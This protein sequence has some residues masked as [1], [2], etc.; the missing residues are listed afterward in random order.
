MLV[1]MKSGNFPGWELFGGRGFLSW[2][3]S[4]VGVVQK[5]DLFGLV[6]TET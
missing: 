1:I 4:V 3:M 2:E 5:P 6:T